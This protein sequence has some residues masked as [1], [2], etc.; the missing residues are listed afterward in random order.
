[1]TELQQEG[2]LSTLT[3]EQTDKLFHSP[4]MRRLFQKNASDEYALIWLLSKHMKDSGIEKIYLKDMVREMNLPLP[5]VTAIARSLQN[6]GLVTW[7]HDGN[8]EEGTYIMLTELAVSSVQTRR[9]ALHS[10]HQRVVSM[11]MMGFLEACERE[12]LRI[13]P[14]WHIEKQERNCGAGY[15]A[16]QEI[17]RQEAEK[18]GGDAP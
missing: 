14:Q 13:K 11:R 10:Y 8:G 12:G 7:T 1:M 15:A 6:K 17:L 2:V 9:Q 16:M 3:P 4:A 18:V 5:K